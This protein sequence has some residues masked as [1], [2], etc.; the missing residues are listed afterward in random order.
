MREYNKNIPITTKN[1]IVINLIDIL[2]NEQKSPQKII[3]LNNNNITK[4]I[5]K[6]NINF[7]KASIQQPCN[8]KKIK[9]VYN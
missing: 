8:I 2:P 4:T 3:S 7:D 9:V 6:P 1:K 5:S